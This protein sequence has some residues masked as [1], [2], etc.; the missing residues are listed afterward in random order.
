MSLDQLS[1]NK[2]SF[3]FK[4]LLKLILFRLI[5]C[6]LYERGQKL[7]EKYGN[8]GRVYHRVAIRIYNRQMTESVS[9]G[10]ADADVVSDADGESVLNYT[11]PV[12]V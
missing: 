2:V 12:I 5:R 1:A 10:D 3:L 4:L 9:A 6:V 8:N 7:M 11:V